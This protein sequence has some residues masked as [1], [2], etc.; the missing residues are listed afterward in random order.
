M[1]HTTHNLDNF[2]FNSDFEI[3]QHLVYLKHM[4]NIII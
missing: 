4:I 2:E 3:Q 1:I